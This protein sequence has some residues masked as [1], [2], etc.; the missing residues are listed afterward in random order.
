[1]STLAGGAAGEGDVGRQLLNEARK[2]EELAADA[3]R[4]ANATAYGA[5]NQFLNRFKV[6]LSRARRASQAVFV[7]CMLAGAGDFVCTLSWRRRESD[8]THEV[9]A[10][11]SVG[12]R[13][14]QNLICVFDRL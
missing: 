7:S 9:C 10:M 1:M 12:Q 5:F 8:R 2:H 6:R 4:R 11:Q 13:H 3:R 14:L